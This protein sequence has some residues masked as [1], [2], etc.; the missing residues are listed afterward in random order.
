MVEIN[1]YSRAKDGDKKLSANFTVREFACSDGSDAVL[2]APRL[3]MVL[4]S[5]RSRFGRPVTINSAYRTPQKN[6]AVGGA[7]QSQHCYGTAADIV[8]KGVSPAKVAACARELMPDWG[9]VGIYER[10]GFTHVDVREEK[11]D[12]RGA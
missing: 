11:A 6:A 5:I 8:V 2:V 3:V 4:Q 9:G 12:W 7:A 1:A 10:Q